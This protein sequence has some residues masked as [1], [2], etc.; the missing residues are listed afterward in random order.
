MATPSKRHEPCVILRERGIPCVLW[1]EDALAKNGVPTVVF[2][3]HLL[4]A[5]VDE[6]ALALHEAGWTDS[7]PLINHF[8]TDSAGK[9][10][11][12][13]PGFSTVAKGS[14]TWP[15]PPPSQE[16]PGPTTTVLLLAADWNITDQ[17]LSQQLS[18]DF[19]PSLPL[20]LG[21]LIDS[22]LDSPSNTALR[23]RLVTYVSYLYDHCA[24]LKAQSFAEN[25]KPEH[26]QFHCDALSKTTLGTAPFIE[27][28]RQ[29]REEVR[30]GKRQPHRWT[31]YL[32]GE[33]QPNHPEP[34]QDNTGGEFGADEPVVVEGLAA[35]NMSDSTPLTEETVHNPEHTMRRNFDSGKT[36]TTSVQESCPDDAGGEPLTG[37]FVVKE[38]V[39]VG[40]L[41][42]SNMSNSSF[43]TEGKQQLPE[44]ADALLQ[45][46]SLGETDTT[47]V[48]DS[49]PDEAGGEPCS[50]GSVVDTPVGVE[51]LA[52]F[53]PNSTSLTEGKEL[54]EH[55]GALRPNAA[56]EE[57]APA[58]IPVEESGPEKAGKCPG[59]G[60][61]FST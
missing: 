3:L 24:L 11:L 4:V 31:W 30:A 18:E 35:S 41:E 5:N 27:E 37:G 34:K 22:L 33:V 49:R 1:F 53:T 25:L 55:S 56:S 51:A 38:Q 59:G 44:P 7:K 58:P 52:D 23:A 26:R 32:S 21:A 8:L 39:V 47:S 13:P 28:Q 40:T 61:T 43:S 50:G 42:D 15:P 16:P 14:R 57:A 36:A 20:L 9:R 6:A 45:D 60:E 46:V 2:D 29:V 54:Q 10:R 12:N 48:K 17:D 19:T